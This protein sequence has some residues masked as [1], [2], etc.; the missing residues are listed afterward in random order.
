MKKLFSK[1]VLA[2][3]TA[4]SLVTSVS[5]ITYAASTLKKI[6]AY[7]NSAIKVEVGG[8]AVNL[9]VDGKRLDPIIYE[10]RTYVPAKP[11][12]E[13]LG[14]TV[15]WDGSRQAV[16]I[17]PSGETPP[18]VTAPSTGG[19]T[20]GTSGSAG[21]ASSNKGTL[22]DPVK[23]GT[24]FTYNDYYNYNPGVSANWSAK[25]TL[26]VKKAT[27]ISKDDIEKLGFKRPTEEDFNYLM[28]DLHLKTENAKFKNG[29]DSLYD[30]NYLDQYTPY[31]WGSKTAT[32]DGV[33]G[34]TDYGFDGSLN[35]NLRELLK[36]YPKVY[37]G[38]SKSF[39]VSGKMILPVLKTGESYL[40]I[41]RQDSKLEYDDSFIYFK[42]K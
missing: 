13:A 31:V 25:Y 1:K 24:A 21:S 29:S 12:A 4:V 2:V 20:S 10:G 35:S 40:V 18:K 11:V 3:V 23:L 38:D 17:T 41:R 27:P 8:S 28:L 36:D 42:L 26:T 32:G 39:E 19:G 14:A 22:S 16:V 5:S 7:Q 30:Y 9:T 37:E 6:T 33:I 34:G 15:Q